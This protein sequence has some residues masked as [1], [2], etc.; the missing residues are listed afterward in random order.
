MA[1]LEYLESVVTKHTGGDVYI[2]SI[3]KNNKGFEQT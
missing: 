1:T 3:T 2:I